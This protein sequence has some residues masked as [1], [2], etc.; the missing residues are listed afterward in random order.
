MHRAFVRIRAWRGGIAVTELVGRE[1]ELRPGD[2]P[3][4][5]INRTDG[6]AEVQPFAPR[7]AKRMQDLAKGVQQIVTELTLGE[8]KAICLAA[9]ELSDHP[10]RLA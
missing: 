1:T 4:Q 9:S 8:K 6:L 2:G 7:A 3:T 10:T 5:S